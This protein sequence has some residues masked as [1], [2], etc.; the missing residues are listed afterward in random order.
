ML[1]YE[2]IDVNWYAGTMMLRELLRLGVRKN[3]WGVWN[4]NVII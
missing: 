1:K 4:A 2:R 3:E